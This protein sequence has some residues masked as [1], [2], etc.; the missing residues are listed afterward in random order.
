MVAFSLS[1]STHTAAKLQVHQ[2]Q[3]GTFWQPE[4]IFIDATFLKTL[5]TCEF[6]NGMVEVVKVRLF[7]FIFHSF[8]LKTKNKKKDRHHLE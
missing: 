7:T 2:I 3:N 5:P 6:L 1:T 8:L 4:Y